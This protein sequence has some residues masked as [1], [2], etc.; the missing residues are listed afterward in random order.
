MMWLYDLFEGRPE[1][2]EGTYLREGIQLKYL[3]SE[4]NA[5]GMI[6][7]AHLVKPTQMPIEALTDFIYD[8]IVHYGKNALLLDQVEI[9]NREGIQGYLLKR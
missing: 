9:V 4:E 2:N 8:S 7:D 1:I 3:G 6:V 5:N